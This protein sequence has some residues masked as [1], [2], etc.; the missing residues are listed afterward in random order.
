MLDRHV[1]KLAEQVRETL[2]AQDWIPDMVRPRGR[3][4]PP[5]A[6]LSSSA[7]ERAQDWAS[8][9]KL[10]TGLVVLTAGALA[11]R[12]YKKSKYCRKTRRARRAR[13]GGRL[14][15]VVVAGD[16]K[17]PLTRSLSLDLERRGFIVYI[18]CNTL[19]DE[20]MVQNLSRPDVRPLGIDIT[21]VWLIPKDII[22]ILRLDTDHSSASKCWRLHRALCPIH[23]G[24]PRCCPGGQAKLPQPEIRHSHPVS[25]LPNLTHSYNSAVQ[26]RRS[27]QHT[28]P[29][30]HPHHPSIPSTPDRQAHLFRRRK[31][32]PQNPRLHS[33]H[34]VV[35]KSAFPRPRGN[36][37][38]GSVGFH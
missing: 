13:N 19:D 2:A 32:S 21:D 38:L 1:D 31:A 37:L 10:L 18:A 35:H 25:E 8:R 14:E 12:G 4:Q 26:F 20:A 11:Y 7:Y 15:V 17:L 23:T 16:P 24:S 27:L 3:P 34:H 29:L 22:S 30:P 33:V 5:P 6:A 9:H 36:S 28:P